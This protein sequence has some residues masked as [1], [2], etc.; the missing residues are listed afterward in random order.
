MRVEIISDREQWNRFV[1]SQP[2]GNVTQTY[3]WGELGDHLGGDVLRLG[4]LE[5]GVLRARW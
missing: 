5:D 2:T 4:A 1:E 3:E